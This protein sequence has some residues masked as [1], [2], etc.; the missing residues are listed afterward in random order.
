[1]KQNAPTSSE[2]D[3][4]FWE[5]EHQ[6]NFISKKDISTLDYIVVPVH[7]LPFSSPDN[8]PE[9]MEEFA[10]E[11]EIKKRIQYKMINLYDFSNIE[12]KEKFGFANLEEL[13]NYEQNFTLF[14]RA[15]A[16]WGELLYHK[17][18]F[19]RAR[20]ILEYSV[21]IDSDISTVYTTLGKIYVQT[22]SLDKLEELIE[23][24]TASDFPRKDSILKTLH[25]CKL[26]Y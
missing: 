17:N 3:N 22:N 6:A 18:E 16:K 14:L 4:N 7:A 5:R 24:V 20:Q 23:L 25:L 21:S 1:M 8:I 15:L 19:A 26:E 2:E 10:L 9:N 11:Q 13:S 12:L